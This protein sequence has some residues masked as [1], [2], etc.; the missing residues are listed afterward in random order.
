[1]TLTTDPQPI[2]PIPEHICP[3]HQCVMEWIDYEPSLYGCDGYWF[4]QQCWE[5]EEYEIRRGNES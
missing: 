1:M 3:I 2:D 5:D 4:C